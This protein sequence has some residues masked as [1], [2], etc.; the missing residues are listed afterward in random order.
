[1]NNSQITIQDILHAILSHLVIIILTAALFGAGAWFYT[2]RWVPKMYRTNVTFY[3][4]GNVERTDDS[5]TTG[6]INLSR[7]LASTYSYIFRTN[8]VFKVAA[9][10]LNEMGYSTNYQTIKSMTVVT[11]TNTEIFTATFSSSDR[12]HLKLIADTVADVGV[13]RIAEIVGTGG[14]KILDYAEEPTAPY[15]P[16]VRGNTMMGVIIGLLFAC[17]IVVIRALTDTTIWSE[18]DLTKQYNIPILGS[19]PQLA[20]LDKQN[21]GKE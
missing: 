16:D 2:T 1:M 7:Q 13:E 21:T 9:E 19:I 8:A 5:I 15:S 18:E 17:A 10:K 6:E 14:A 4:M 12:E 11:T 20:A 3:A